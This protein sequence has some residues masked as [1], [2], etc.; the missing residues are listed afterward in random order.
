MKLKNIVL[1]TAL[2]LGF[3]IQAQAGPFILAGTDADD[4]GSTSGG[5]NLSGWLFMQRALENLTTSASLNNGFLNVVNLGSSAAARAGQAAASAFGLSSLA[6]TWSFS[7]ID[8]IAGITDFFAGNGAVNIN[9]T[10][11]IMMDSGNNVTGGSDSAERALFTT[12]ATA[13]DG[14]LGGG[15]GLFSQS[16]GYGW[17]T[18]LLPS[19]T[20]VSGGGS[21]ANLTAVGNLAFPGLTN[22]DLT[23]GPR[24]NRFDNTGALPIL[25]VD[26]TGIAVIIGS[27]GGSVTAP[28]PTSAPEPTIL[29]LLGLGLAAIGFTRRK[30]IVS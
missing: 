27:D 7:N 24:H 6:P 11:I 20:I 8:G 14:F 30:K 18:A 23:G 25:A 21:G 22:A 3:S 19:L 13:I 10:G 5:A 2:G 16:N 4:H 15:G 9:N 12:N 26:N 17:V 29:S 28:K 1:L